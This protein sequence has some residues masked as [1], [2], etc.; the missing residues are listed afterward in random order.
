MALP[1]NGTDPRCRSA[2]EEL[3]RQ[4]GPAIMRLIENDLKPL[5]ILTAASLHNALALDLAMGGSSNT[6]LHTLAVAHEAG[7]RMDLR[8]LNELADRVPYLCK[9]SPASRSV[10][11]QDVDRAGGI[12]AILAELQRIPGLSMA[13]R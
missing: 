1:G 2:R 11:I 4:T 6:I 7:I 10:H 12:S 5:D 3:I 8:A 13:T 9:V